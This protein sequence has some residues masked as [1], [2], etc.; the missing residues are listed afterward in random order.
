MPCAWH[1]LWCRVCG[2]RPPHPAM[3]RLNTV[4]HWLACPHQQ[5][6][7]RPAG[8]N[9]HLGCALHRVVPGGKRRTAVRQTQ[10]QQPLTPAIG[11]HPASMRDAYVPLCP[12]C[13]CLCA[14]HVRQRTCQTQQAATVLLRCQTTSCQQQTSSSITRQQQQQ[15]PCRHQTQQQM[16]S[17]LV[18]AWA[19]TTAAMVLLLLLPLLLWLVASLSLNGQHPGS[20]GVLLWQQQQPAG[21]AG[22]AQL[23]VG[24][25]PWTWQQLLCH[26][27]HWKAA[28]AH[29]SCPREQAAAEQAVGKSLTQ[30]WSPDNVEGTTAH[31]MQCAMS[32]SMSMPS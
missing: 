12:C 20:L 16:Q 4:S 32:E 18:L 27:S 10:R 15:Q 5:G 21:P 6:S 24:V 13:C 26:S 3:P 8:P 30:A 31:G 19:C 2:R 29:T 9:R 28:A 22:K 1:A 23:V 7:I 14:G 17:G 25:P 11:S